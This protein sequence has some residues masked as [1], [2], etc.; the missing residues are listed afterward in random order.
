MARCA[1]KKII[2]TDSSKFFNR[3][4]ARQLPLSEVTMVITDDGIPDPARQALAR[5]GV[6]LVVVPSDGAV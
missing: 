2:L 5:H 1:R 6:K 4:V 3:G